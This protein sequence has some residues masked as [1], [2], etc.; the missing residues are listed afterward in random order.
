MQCFWCLEPEAG[1]VLLCFNLGCVEAS[2]LYPLASF[3]TWVSFIFRKVLLRRPFYYLHHA[4]E[5]KIS[6]K[7]EH[8]NSPDIL[9]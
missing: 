7:T 3:L 4:K 9:G 2:A 8:G 1:E 5:G 6:R